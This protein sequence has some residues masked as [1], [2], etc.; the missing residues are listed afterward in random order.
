MLNEPFDPG[1]L[2]QALGEARAEVVMIAVLDIA[3]LAL[4]K[5][6]AGRAKDLAV[7]PELEALLN[8]RARQD[9]PD[10]AI[11]KDSEAT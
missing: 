5:R 10:V 1:R 3:G 8:L 11:G 4:T 6:A 2:L 7:L 9:A